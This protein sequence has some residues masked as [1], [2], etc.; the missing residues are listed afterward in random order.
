[1]ALLEICEQGPTIPIADLMDAIGNLTHEDKD[2]KKTLIKS[3][4][5]TTSTV[6]EVPSKVVHQTMNV[7]VVESTPTTSNLSASSETKTSVTPQEAVVPSEDA[8][9]SNQPVKAAPSS[10]DSHHRG[11]AGPAPAGNSIAP[12]GTNDHYPLQR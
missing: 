2:K 6:A 10:S 8:K 7:S 4:D 12:S 1:M 5:P 3:P 9:S 11:T